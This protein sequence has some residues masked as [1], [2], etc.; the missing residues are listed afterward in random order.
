MGKFVRVAGVNDVAEG[1]GTTV[2]ADG[3]AIA[4]F[5]VAG[6]FYAIHNACLH[7]GGP[8]G[9]GELD[10]QMVTCP[11]HAWR[12]DVT[13]GI[14]EVNPDVKIQQYP[15]KVAGDDVLVEI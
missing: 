10:G 13:T 11:W 6:T 12:Y 4:L 1:S 2:Q 8:L 15:V 7:R 3:Q 5:K 9:E 14:N